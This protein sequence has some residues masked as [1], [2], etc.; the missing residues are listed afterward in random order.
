MQHDDRSSNGSDSVVHLPCEN[1]LSLF[2]L[3]LIEVE[4][5]DLNSKGSMI[6]SEM[7]RGIDIFIAASS[8]SADAA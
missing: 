2:S 3:S 7:E 8:W 1:A 6:A 5:M 4:R